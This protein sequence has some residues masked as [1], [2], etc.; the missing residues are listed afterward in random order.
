MNAIATL[1]TITV[2]S[3]QIAEF[4]GKRHDDILR[5][6]RKMFANIGESG[7][8]R[9]FAESYLNE[10]GKEQPEYVFPK[11]EA[12][13]VASKYRDE[14]RIQLVDY[15]AKLEAI[16]LE[17]ASRPHANYIHQVRNADGTL[18][19]GPVIGLTCGEIWARYGDKSVK[20]YAQKLS[21]LM[22][23][24]GC[25]WEGRKGVLGKSTARLFDPIKVERWMQ[26]EGL[27]TIRNWAAQAQLSKTH[28]Y[29]LLGQLDLPGV[30]G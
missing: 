18:Y 2:T 13:F 7:R 10:Q 30:L 29:A 27:M 19:Y 12:L 26:V 4:A 25:D 24:A 20:R 16:V 23:A 9:K 14:I 21:T 28:P 11:R 22:V 17:A 15:I 8:L 6:I 5:S 3:R 1:D